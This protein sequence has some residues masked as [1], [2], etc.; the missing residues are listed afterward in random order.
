MFMLICDVLAFTEVS[1]GYLFLLHAC[2]RCMKASARA[3]YCVALS[4]QHFNLSKQ[5]ILDYKCYRRHLGPCHLKLLNNRRQL[6]SFHFNEKT[7]D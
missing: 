6:K 7:P 1:E 5:P 2:L 3:D 4:L